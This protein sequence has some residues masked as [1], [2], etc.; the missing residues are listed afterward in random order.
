MLA[1]ALINKPRLIFL[2]EPSTGL[3]PQSRRN[4][5]D[6]LKQLKEEG[7][8]LILTTHSMEEAE[9]LCDEIAIMDQGTIIAQSS[10]AELIHQH[11]GG[12]SIILP[13]KISKQQLEG[14]PYA[15]RQQNGEVVIHTNEIHL[16]LTLLMEKKIDLQ[17]VSIHSANLED[18]F[19]NLTG[20]KLRE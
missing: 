5:W 19:L 14:I 17:G 6:I 20:K 4:L 2:D 11:G 7:R 10:P 13:G 18:V 3:D 16:G 9:Y 12:S 8:T 1:L 15:V